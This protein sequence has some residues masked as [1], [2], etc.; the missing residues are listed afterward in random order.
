MSSNKGE[1][2]LPIARASI[3]GVFGQVLEATEDATWLQEQ[4]ACFVTLSQQGQL[5][6]CVGSIEAHR[7]L[8]DDVKNNAIA[9]AFKDTRFSPLLSDE[10]DETDIE[11]SLLSATQALDFSNEQEALLQLQPGVDGVVFEY[12]HY[13]STF[14]PQVW[15]QLPDVDV[16]MAHLKHKAGLTPDFWADQVKLSRYTV[17]KWKERDFTAS[18]TV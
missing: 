3:A 6:G 18:K 7:S 17:S 16:F 15:E 8:L 12:A 11:V 13:R 2:L 10:F 14:L 9:A 4:A 5:R 1:I